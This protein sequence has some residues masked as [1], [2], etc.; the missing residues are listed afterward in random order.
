MLRKLAGFFLTF[1]S[2]VFF[3]ISQRI[4]YFW[5]TALFFS[6][7]RISPV[8]PKFFRH[9][10]NLYRWRFDSTLWSFTTRGALARI[11]MFPGCKVLDLCCGDGSIT[12]LFYSDI[13]ALVHGVDLDAGAIEIAN[14][15]YSNNTI[16]FFH[17]DIIKDRFPRDDYDFVI[18]NAGLSYLTSNEQDQLLKKILD[19]VKISFLF[20][21]MVPVA[22]NFADHKREFS[23]D[24]ELRSFLGRFFGKVEITKVFER[25]SEAFYFTASN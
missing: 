1:I 17:R 22:H 23:S 7:W 5:A 18:C 20:V 11:K 21:G 13:P 12:H 19:E 4:A 3:L 2:A 25:G 6:E 8:M 14:R 24:N 9:D 15:K 10:L 16:S